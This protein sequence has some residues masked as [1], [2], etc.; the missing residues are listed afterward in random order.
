MRTLSPKPGGSLHRVMHAPPSA[1]G[2]GLGRPRLIAQRVGL[3]GVL[4]ALLTASWAGAFVSP[5]YIPSK[6]WSGYIAAAKG[7]S[8]DQ[9]SGSWTVPSARCSARKTAF[10]EVS[11]WVG[12][13]VLTGVEQIGTDT[14]CYTTLHRAAFG[15]AWWEV[16]PAPSHT[17]NRPVSPGDLLHASVSVSGHDVTLMLE[18]L[19]KHWTFIKHSGARAPDLSAAEW[20]V[21]DPAANCCQFFPL[22]EFSPVTFTNAHAR[23]TNRSSG[24]LTSPPWAATKYAMI[25][26]KPPRLLA[27]PS[28]LSA[29]G[30]SFSVT[31]TD[32][33]PPPQATLAPADRRHP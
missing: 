1:S 17:I 11:T 4:G 21:E 18:D 7:V 28:A 31:R 3:L 27:W 8:M 20:I 29:N 33:S 2:A 14:S 30:A 9:V 13:G 6:I 32:R 26:G 15:S 16:Y 24:T 22:A 5:G 12:L 25:A 23:S 10:S 19:S